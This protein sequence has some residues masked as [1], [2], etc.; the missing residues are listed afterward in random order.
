MQALILA[1]GLGSRMKE[2]T[3]ETTKT[4]VE[5]NGKSLIER[6]LIQIESHNFSKII[7]VDGYKSEIMQDYVNQI[8]IKTP[9][10]FITNKE[11]EHTNNIY[12]VFLAKE[13]MLT[14]DTIMFE[15][16]LIFADEILEEVINSNYPNLAVVS[17]FESWMDGTVIKKDEENNILDFIPKENFNFK[18]IESYYKTVNIYKFSKEFSENTYFPF[19]EAQMQSFGK[20]EYYETILR[21]I[22]QLD[23]TIIRALDIKD[24]PW[25]E[26][27]DL[28]DLDVASSLFNT[29]PEAKY[30][31]LHS[32]FGG[33]WRYPKLIDFCY[34]VNPFY[35]PQRMLDEIQSNLKRLIIDYPSGLEVNSSLVA[36]Y[37]NIPTEYTVV[38][39]GAAE[40]IKSFMEFEEGSFG[41]IAPTF[42]E[43]PNRLSKDKIVKYYPVRE[44]YKYTVDDIIE[45]YSN[46]RVDN[47]VLIN[48]DNPTG[49]YIR[50]VD[51]VR[52]VEW[53]K[54]KK[55]KLILD[56]SFGDFVDIEEENSLIDKQILKQYPNLILI[57]SISKSFGVPGVRL[58][59]LMSSD[60][61]LISEI[62]S[63]VSIWNINSFGEFFL[64]IFEKYKKDYEKGLKLFYNVRSEYYNKLNQIKYLE[65][66]QS[67]ANYFTCRI[68]PDAK[69][70]SEEL[71]IKLLDNDKL[72]IKDLSSKDGFVG[73]N[74]IRLAVKKKDENDLIVA[75]LNEYL[76]E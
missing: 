24:I 32:R 75:K 35:P 21:T 53:C 19:L 65:V 73:K 60:L 43:Y 41:I 38:G 61:N 39:N 17:K 12:S 58:G 4:M 15:S 49:N 46:Y 18:E 25:Y 9:V 69:I 63:D 64:Q 57:K 70:T 6:L 55:I 2:Y 74:Y 59:F 76:G 13:K 8:N 30:K 71:A 14:E 34:L 48:P 23:S 56:E 72:L 3:K 26:I 66:L 22:T 62:K 29:T 40:L 1:A 36:K 31:S 27:D 7:I 50:K 11:F 16:D 5:I 52:L 44:K 51:V 42:E 10:E 20:N 54:K 28:Q 68:L 45:F 37:Y 67:Q 47:L 33:Y